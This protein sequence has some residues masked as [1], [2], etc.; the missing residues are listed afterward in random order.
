V[1]KLTPHFQQRS[2]ERFGAPMTDEQAEWYWG[3]GYTIRNFEE[4]NLE[5]ARRRCRAY[6]IVIIQHRAA[7]MVRSTTTNQFVTIF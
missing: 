3:R 5:I 1:S 4:L 7:V 6:R 2:T